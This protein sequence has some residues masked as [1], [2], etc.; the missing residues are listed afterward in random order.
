MPRYLR[1]V[2]K[3][4]LEDILRYDWAKAAKMWQ[5]ERPEVAVEAL[6]GFYSNLTIQNTNPA[7]RAIN[8]MDDPGISGMLG[9]QKTLTARG[10]PITSKYVLDSINF[11]GGVY[12][13]VLVDS[14]VDDVVLGAFAR[15]CTADVEVLRGLDPYITAGTVLSQLATTAQTNQADAIAMAAIKNFEYEKFEGHMYP[16]LVKK[17]AKRNF[18]A[19]YP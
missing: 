9:E 6:D 18:K 13:N 16:E 7:Q 5:K 4:V 15:G 2:T 17:I 19:L 1:G 8:L 11:W 12:D 10:Y 14:T 3:M